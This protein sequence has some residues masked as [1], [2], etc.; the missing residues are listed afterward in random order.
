MVTLPQRPEA[1]QVL[2]E[3][4]ADLG[5]R[6]VNAA[7]WM[8]GDTGVLGPYAVEALGSSVLVDSQ[9]V[10][11]HQHRNLALAI[12]AA[13]E[14]AGKHGFPVT[15]AAIAEGI[16]QTRW[17]GR[18]ERLNRNG[19]EWILDVGHNPAG[20]AALS[21]GLRGVLGD[22]KLP[23]LVFSCLRDKAIGEMAQI[24][25]PLF[26]RVILAPIHSARAA[27]MDDLLAAAWAT[28]TKA[29]AAESVERALELAEECTPGGVVVV[30]GSVYLIGEV[31]PLLVAGRNEQ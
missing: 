16:R 11:A 4:A 5:V 9:L 2:D 30:C 22:G 14:L 28:G 26:E 17:P 3:V 13:V 25:F 10:G 27:A 6:A 31:R 7:A 12:A 29:V 18:L 23:M 19:V 21:S 24:L 20:V 8:P 15:P 1:N